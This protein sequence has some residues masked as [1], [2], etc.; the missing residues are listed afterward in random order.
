MLLQPLL[1]V[2]FFIAAGPGHS[3]GGSF[4]PRPYDGWLHG[5]GDAWI[6]GIGS[7]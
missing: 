3:S 4:R 2:D 1:G 6:G 5:A 7:R